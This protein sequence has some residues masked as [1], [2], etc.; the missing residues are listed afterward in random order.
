MIRVTVWNENLHEKN[1]PEVTRLYPGGI[2]GHL[3]GYLNTLEGIEARTATQDQPD[4][5]LSD[6]VLQNTD[7]LLWWGHCSH[8]LV[9]DEIASKVVNRVLGGM[10]FIALHSAHYS[11]P[12]RMLMGTTCSL[13]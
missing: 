6:E 9:P 2:H 13:R 3:A 5:G 10:G 1:D 11:K 7:V 4:C 12:F 8:H